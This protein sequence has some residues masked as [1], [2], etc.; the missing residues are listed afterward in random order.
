MVVVARSFQP[1]GF[2]L[3]H[4][5]FVVVF[6][7]DKKLEILYPSI[8][9]KMASAL[10]NWHPSDKSA[11]KILEPWVQV[12]YAFVSSAVAF[13]GTCNEHVVCVQWM[14]VFTPQVMESFVARTIVPKLAYCLQMELQIN[15]HQQ[16]IGERRKCCFYLRS[17]NV[18]VCVWYCC[19]LCVCVCVQVHLSG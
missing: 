15:P 1:P 18:I 13:S 3:G 2:E 5:F 10:A 8:R 9:Y 7:T 12:M 19:L 14:Q 11:H 6:C 16:K 4:W 17:S